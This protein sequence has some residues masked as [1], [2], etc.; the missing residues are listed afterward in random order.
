[1][2]DIS[3]ALIVLAPLADGYGIYVTMEAVATKSYGLG[4]VGSLLS[5]LA[6]LLL[7]KV[8]W[9]GVL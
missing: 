7:G 3:S 5:L 6:G 8:V 4:L 2:Y 9:G 1:M